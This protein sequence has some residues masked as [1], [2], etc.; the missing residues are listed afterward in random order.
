MSK[1]S[2]Y[3]LVEPADATPIWFSRTIAGLKEN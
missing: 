2:V 3:M 1:E